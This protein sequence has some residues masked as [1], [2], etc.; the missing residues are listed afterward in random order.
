MSIFDK[1]KSVFSSEE[2]E[3]NSQAHKNDWYVFEWSV[4][5]TGEIFYVGY[6]YGDDSKS[7]GFETYHG[8]R[9]KEKLDVECKIIKD[10]LE[11]DRSTW[12]ATRRIEE[13]VERNWQ[14]DYQSCDS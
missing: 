5:D 10:N 13:S 7:F 4:K 3:T 2:K 1:L 14:C 12:F 9:I 6:G 8:E 11:E